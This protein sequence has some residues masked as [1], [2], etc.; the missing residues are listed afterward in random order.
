MADAALRTF[1]SLTASTL[2]NHINAAR[3]PD[4]L[5]NLCSALWRHQGKGEISYD[6]A[7]FLESAIG[8]RRPWRPSGMKIGP[9]RGRIGS[10]FEEPRK[11]HRS[12]D[13]KASRERRRMLG[14]SGAIPPH[15]RALFTEGERAVLAIIAGEVKHHGQ[16]DLPIDKI[17]A[18]A[19]CCRTTVQNALNEAR[20]GGL[21]RITVRPQ[22]GR[23]NLPNVVEIISR[24]WM[25]WLR[26]GPTAHR[27]NRVQNTKIVNPSKNIDIKK[28]QRKS[29]AT[30]A[31]A[32]GAFDEGPGRCSPPRSHREVAA[33]GAK[34]RG[35]S[36]PTH[37]APLSKRSTRPLGPSP[38][39]ACE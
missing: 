35:C 15:L 14:G 13:R 32:Q 37:S 29:E 24:E 34:N 30:A 9:L 28:Y 5:D 11:P 7:V 23:K 6:E 39:R 21:I 26:R 20:R 2:Y 33:S 3:S 10:I 22:R 16:C 4:Q 12:H 27:P 36:S 19:G 25:T 1:S 38:A 18:L 17:A 31:A 8:K